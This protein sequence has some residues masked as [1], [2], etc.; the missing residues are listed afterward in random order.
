METS[1]IPLPPKSKD[2]PGSS[3]PTGA[4][5]TVDQETDPALVPD[6]SLVE[7]SLTPAAPSPPNTTAAPSTVVPVAELAPPT[8]PPETQTTEDTTVQLPKPFTALPI[9]TPLP[10]LENFNLRPEQKKNPVFV[11]ICK[12]LLAYG[13]AWQSAMDLVGKPR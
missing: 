3:I 9:K 7:D 5:A 10:N 1:P 2:L 11:G 6:L 13:N 8:P 4:S 12:V